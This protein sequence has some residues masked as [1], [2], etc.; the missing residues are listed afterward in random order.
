MGKDEGNGKG[1]RRK[2]R[3]EAWSME[4]RKKERWK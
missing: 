2:G 3:Q 4:S 1:N